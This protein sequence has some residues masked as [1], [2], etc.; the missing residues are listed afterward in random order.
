M[1]KTSIS[2]HITEK[3]TTL[4]HRP[5][6]GL[7]LGAVLSQPAMAGDANARFQYHALFNPTIG[8]LQAEARGRVMIYDGL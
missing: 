1:M 8:Q 4:N 6:V 2:Q 5:L 3:P 7:L